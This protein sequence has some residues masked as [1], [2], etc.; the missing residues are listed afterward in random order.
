MAKR[1]CKTC[2][3]T[4]LRRFDP[5]RG[6][7]VCNACRSK[8]RAEKRRAERE[9]APPSP[10]VPAGPKPPPESLTDGILR[11]S[12]EAAIL[13]ELKRNT[14][15]LDQLRAFVARVSGMEGV[16]HEA[17]QVIAPTSVAP[18]RRAGTLL[19]VASDWHLEEIVE[20]GKV[21]YRNE[22]N[23][24]IAEA[25]AKRF[26]EAVVWA[27]GNVRHSHDVDT[28][29]LALL[30]DLITGYL[31]PDNVESNALAPQEA[32]RF[33]YAVIRDGIDYLLEHG[34]LKTLIIPVCDGNHG[35]LTD[36]MRANTR[37]ENSIEQL[38]Y[39]FLAQHYYKNPRVRF[40]SEPGALTHLT[41]YGRRIRFM[42]GD[43]IRYQG[44]IG[45]IT[46]PLRKALHRLDTL[47]PA[48]LTVVGHF[49][50]LTFGARLI[51]NGSLIGYSPY[52]VAIGAEYEA[53]QQACV[54]LDSEH[55]DSIKIP[56]WVTSSKEQYK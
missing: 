27:L 29:I 38:L 49:H 1:K 51:V 40:V 2:S 35:R 14:T 9:A 28:L 24:E 19:A 54:L 22:Y 33:A 15:E 26:F 34:G 16:L 42:H 13:A 56:L 47:L 12:R 25:R 37:V 30:G 31:H 8:A 20:P 45:G 44:G 53:P 11:K 3:T 41:V 43:N 46:I 55:F 6:G 21:G 36:K 52:C 10:E 39:F 5:S 23:L 32:I 18:G 17:P 4:D 48:A 50:Q 7:S